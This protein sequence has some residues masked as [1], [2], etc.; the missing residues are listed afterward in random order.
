MNDNKKH[1]ELLKKGS[2]RLPTKGWKWARIGREQ[3]GNR[4]RIGWE[5]GRKRAGSLPVLLLLPAHCFTLL[6]YLLAFF[7]GICYDCG[8]PELVPDKKGSY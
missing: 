3:G 6:L 5:Q 4:A 8:D 1:I 7:R 2:V